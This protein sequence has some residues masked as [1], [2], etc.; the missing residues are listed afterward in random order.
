MRWSHDSDRLNVFQDPFKH[1]PRTIRITLASRVSLLFLYPEILFH[2]FCHSN[3]ATQ[4]ESSICHELSKIS[5]GITLGGRKDQQR[6]L[7]G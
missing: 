5:G 7:G 1:L 2:G 3:I 4:D 6:F